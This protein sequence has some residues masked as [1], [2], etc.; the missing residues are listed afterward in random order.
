MKMNAGR[1]IARERGI[2][3]GMSIY[4][5]IEA[6][7]ADRPWLVVKALSTMPEEDRKRLKWVLARS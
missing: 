6:L 2:S 5:K 3:S 7:M 1:Y 4:K